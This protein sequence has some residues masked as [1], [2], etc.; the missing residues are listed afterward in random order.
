M[1]CAARGMLAIF[2]LLSVEKRAHKDSLPLDGLRG[3][4]ASAVLFHHASIWFAYKHRGVWG[5]PSSRLY[6]HIGPAAVTLFFFVSG[7]LFW[8]KVLRTPDR[9][10]WARLLPNRARR[11]LPAYWAA[12]LLILLSALVYT[13]FHLHEPAGRFLEECA[14]WALVGFPILGNTGANGLSGEVLS[15]GVFWTLQMEAMFYILLPLLLWFRASWRFPLLLVL[16]EVLL[17]LSHHLDPTHLG[18]TLA[19]FTGLFERFL[20][21]FKV[22]FFLGMLAAY[23]P[24]KAHWLNW[25]R[26]PWAAIAAIVCLCLELTL[27][28]HSYTVLL[29]LL[30]APTFFLVIAGNT[31]GGL[32]S[33]LPM[34]SLGQVSYS[35][36]IFHGILLFDLLSLWNKH[37]PINTM[38]EPAFAGVIWILGMAAVVFST[39]SYW[40]IERPFTTRRTSREPLPASGRSPRLSP[41]QLS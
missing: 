1:A 33:S 6:A 22:G 28:D 32:F 41:E 17:K 8:D 24:W 13:H 4:L 36:Y 20:L 26:S 10:T 38:S 25:M 2:P 23:R 29:S 37:H 34:R 19:P 11:I 3:L 39:L 40:Y 18:Q 5:E 16:A 15:A 14:R 27:T 35:I 21:M 9:I 7:Y 30:L 12:A 31:F